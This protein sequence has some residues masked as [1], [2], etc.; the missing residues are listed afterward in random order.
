MLCNA[1]N[2]PTGGTGQRVARV[3]LGDAVQDRTPPPA[4]RVA[5]AH[6]RG[7][8]GLYRDPVT[9]DTRELTFANRRLREAG[10]ELVPVSDAELAV[11]TSGRRYVFGTS[12]RAGGFRVESWEYTDQRW[13]PV[14]PWTPS[15]A[16]LTALA[17]TY[18]SDDAETTFVVRVENGALVLWRRP[19]D[20]WT[21]RPIYRDGFH[22]G[23]WI[24]RFR[25]DGSGRPTGLSLSL[26]RVYDMRFERVGS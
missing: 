8:A 25:R 18:H 17:G 26:G 19:A 23:G 3:Y 7:L 2:V 6:L 22:G 24:V 9:G 14:E 15:A 5:E 1:S 12:D 20:T 13:E 11:G 4:A 21:L 10:T 16:D